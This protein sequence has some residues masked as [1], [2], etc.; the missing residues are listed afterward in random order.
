MYV[1]EAIRHAEPTRHAWTIGLASST[2]ATI[3]SL[4]G[5]WLSAHSSIEHAMRVARAENAVLLL[6]SLVASSAL[7]SAHLGET[8][9]AL[10]HLDEGDR[11]FELFAPKGHGVLSYCALSRAGFLLGRLDAAW[12]LAERAVAASSRNPS[13]TAH[14]LLLVADIATYPERFD[15]E[16]GE[17]HYRDALALAE[18]RGMRPLVAHCHLGLGKLYRRTG[19]REQA[20]EHLTT[21]TT[22]YR[23]MD[24]RFWLEKAEAEMMELT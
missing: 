18:P 19:K 10:S 21:A 7:I 12:R 16:H 5:D 1:T 17:V 4:K 24:M 22:M 3:H 11:L 14:A 13:W 15:A 23:E 20:Q 2:A 9:A 6:P 8:E